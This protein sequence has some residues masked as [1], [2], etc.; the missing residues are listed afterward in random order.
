[1]AGRGECSYRSKSWTGTSVFGRFCSYGSKTWT[2]TS[3]LTAARTSSRACPAIS[4]FRED[5]AKQ[6]HGNVHSV[7]YVEGHGERTPDYGHPF[8]AIPFLRIYNGC[9]CAAIWRNGCD[10]GRGERCS[11]AGSGGHGRGS[12]GR[13][14]WGFRLR[15][16]PYELGGWDGRLIPLPGGMRGCAPWG[17]ARSAGGRKGYAPQKKASRRLTFFCGA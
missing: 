8:T 17:A 15:L 7:R 13:P 11:G 10:E 6:P 12:G 1:M 16:F 5:S 3:T 9:Q 4:R 2:H 14:L